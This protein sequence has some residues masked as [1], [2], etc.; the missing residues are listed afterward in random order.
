ME[1]ETHIEHTIKDKL[2][3]SWCGV[4]VKHEFR[5]TDIDHATYYVEQNPDMKE[6][7]C[8]KCLNNIKK[9]WQQ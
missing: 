8:E 4:N 7:V 5:F 6:I 1:R 2:G 3:I 9:I